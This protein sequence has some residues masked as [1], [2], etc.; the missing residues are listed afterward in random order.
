MLLGKSNEKL[1]LNPRKRWYRNLDTVTTNGDYEVTFILTRPQPAFIA[2]LASGFSPVY[3]C[4]VPPKDMRSLQS[5]PAP[6]NLSNSSRTY[7]S[8]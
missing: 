4:H 5:A 3:P 8:K 2:L 7:R 1:R 6:S